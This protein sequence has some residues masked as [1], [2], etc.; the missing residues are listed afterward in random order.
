MLLTYIENDLKDRGYKI[1]ILIPDDNKLIKYYSS[2]GYKY[3]GVHENIEQI[4]MPIM[5]KL[6]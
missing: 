3:L 6:L 5:Y 2:N 4:G 1:I